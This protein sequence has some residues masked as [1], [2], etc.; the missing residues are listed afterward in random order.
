MPISKA[1]LDAIAGVESNFN[2]KAVG[3]KGKAMGMFQMQ[4]IAYQDIQ[5]VDPAYRTIPYSRLKTDAAFQR[6]TAER[7][8]RM[9]QETYKITD[10][11]R[12]ISFYNAGP[13]ARSGPLINRGYVD[14]VKAR[15]G[16]PTLRR[17]Q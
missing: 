7:Y 5:R 10:P 12:L 17:F 8:L 16:N 9:G 3:D 6:Q 11:D 14:K 1:L 4:P 13:K 15:M 2:P